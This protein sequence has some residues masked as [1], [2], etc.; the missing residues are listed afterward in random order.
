MPRKYSRNCGCNENL[1]IWCTIKT[2]P[3]EQAAIHVL[4]KSWGAS[5]VYFPGPQP[6]SIERKH[7]SLLNQGYVVCDKAD[8]IRSVLVAF[9]FENKNTCVLIN[10]V[11]EVFILNIRLPKKAYTGTVFDGELVNNSMFLVYDVVRAAGEDVSQ[12][13][14][15]QRLDAGVAIVKGVIKM[16]SDSVTIRVKTF[17]AV[18]H[19]KQHYEEYMPT[20]P[21]K[22]DGLILTPIFE[23]IKTGTHETL[24]KWKPLEKNTIDFQ[25][26]FFGKKWGMYVLEKGKLVFESELYPKDA[27]PWIQE[28]SIVECQYM[29]NESPRWWK[30]LALRTD[31]KHPNNRRTFY[32]TLT[33]IREDIKYWQLCQV[34]G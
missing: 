27:P 25:F 32:N 31:K 34:E 11:L 7:L 17:A 1:K 5:G 6:I 23:P 4:F 19:T 20:L 26:K 10:R 2:K 9:E 13:N 12:L 30:P 18:H 24:F 29:S 8:G 3:M 15:F 33:N 16:K 21:Y 28:D 22:T 14:L